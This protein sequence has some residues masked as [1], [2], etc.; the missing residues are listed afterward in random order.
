MQACRRCA[1]GVVGP[2]WRHGS[3]SEK[4]PIL[5]TMSKLTERIKALLPTFKS[6]KARD[7][8]YLNDSVDI[9]D[10]ERRMRQIDRANTV[11]AHNLAYGAARP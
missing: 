4:L 10:L 1:F 8:A 2:L 5:L 3:D 9:C 7:E 11:D 6:Q